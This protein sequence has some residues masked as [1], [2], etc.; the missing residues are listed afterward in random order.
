MRFDLI[1]VWNLGFKKL[2]FNLSGFGIW[3]FN[4]GI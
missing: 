2:E 3:I 1:K 4:I